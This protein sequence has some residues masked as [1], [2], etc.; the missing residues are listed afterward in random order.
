[1]S[2][3]ICTSWLNQS[4]ISLTT[5]LC[6]NN[7]HFPHRYFGCSLIPASYCALIFLHSCLALCIVSSAQ[8]FLTFWWHLTHFVSLPYS[9]SLSN[10]IPSRTRFLVVSNTFLP[11]GPTRLLQPRMNTNFTSLSKTVHIQA[12]RLRKRHQIEAWVPG[13]PLNKTLHVSICHCFS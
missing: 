10:L 3:I 9:F 4:D 13:V 2:D 11:T 7:T 8:H 12:K 6:I 1:M 5:F